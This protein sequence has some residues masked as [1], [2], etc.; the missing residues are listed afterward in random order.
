MSKKWSKHGQKIM[1][2]T[3]AKK[4]CNMGP[5]IVQ[6]GP[7]GPEKK[8]IGQKYADKVNM[9]LETSLWLL[10]NRIV[11]QNGGKCTQIL[12]KRPKKMSQKA[13][14]TAVNQNTSQTMI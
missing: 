4:L 3:M 1:W 8:Y 10:R 2:L 5:K 11:A 14:W 9:W 12:Q 6:K 7:K 13:H